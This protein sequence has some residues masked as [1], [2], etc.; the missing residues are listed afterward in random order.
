MIATVSS[1]GDQFGQYSF[2]IDNVTYDAAATPAPAA[3][4]LF[5]TGLGAL[6]LLGWLRRRKAAA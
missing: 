5:S 4:P 3:L 1:A 6:G 2:F